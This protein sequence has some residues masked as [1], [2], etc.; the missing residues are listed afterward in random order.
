MLQELAHGLDS[1]TISPRVVN[2]AL[3][4]SFAI[5]ARTLLD[6]L[7]TDEPRYE[8]D[9]VAQDFFATPEQW[10]N[11]RSAETKALERVHGRVAKE[12]AHLTYARLDVTPEAKGWPFMDIAKDI[13][14]VMD[15]FLGM[16]PDDLLGPRWVEYRKER[17]KAKTA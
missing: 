1:G 5:H 11:A 6:F 10:A 7:C 9:V 3:L 16:L 17:G 15:E 4:E 13:N 14:T 12:V 8:D 2:N